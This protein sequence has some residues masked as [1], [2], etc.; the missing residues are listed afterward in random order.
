ESEILQACYEVCY[1]HQICSVSEY[2]NH[3]PSHWHS[4][5]GSHCAGQRQSPINIKT[6]SVENKNLGAF[7]FTHF[8]DKHAIKHIINT[9]HTGFVF[10]KRVGGGVGHVYSVLQFHFHWANKDSGSTGS[11][12]LLNNTRFPMEVNFTSEVSLDDLLGDVNR[13]SFYRYMGALTTPAATKPW[14]GRCSNTPSQWT[15]L[16]YGIV[17]IRSTVLTLL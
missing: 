10:W 2:C 13:D 7:T 17:V 4:L 9:G 11:E 16:W 6:D 3:S 14:C 15:T 8:N 5:A 1:E 12:H